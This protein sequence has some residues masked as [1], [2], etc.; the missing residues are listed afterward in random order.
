MTAWQRQIILCVVLL[1]DAYLGL[2]HNTGIIASSGLFKGEIKWLASSIEMMTGGIILVRIALGRASPRWRSAVIVFTPILVVLI[3]FVV[4]HTVLTGL[5]R[6]A[7]FNF[8]LSSIGA[9]GLYWAAVYLSIAI[10]LT[11]TYKVQRFANFAQA[12]MMLFGAY[13]A[14]T[15]MWSDR[16]FPI[17]NA[18]KDGILNWELMIWSAISAFVITGLVGLVIDRVVYRRF[19][20]RMVTP[21]IMMIASLGVSMVLRALLYLRF[22]AST[23]RFVPDRDWRLTTSIVEIPTQQLELNIGDR[24]NVPLMDLAANVN[25]YGFAYSKIALVAGIFGIVML[26][27]FLLHRTSLG[28]QMRA[29]ADNSDLAASS[30]IHVERV[31]GSTA[32]LSSGIA[33]FGGAFLAAILPVNPELGLSLLLPAFAVIVLGTIGSMPG[34]IIGALIVG[35][36]RAVSEP[37]LIGAG[38]AL[39]RP[40]ASGFA[41]VT[42]FIFLIGLL[43]LAPQG[44]GSAIQNWN[45]ERIRK[46]RLSQRSKG[47]FQVIKVALVLS[48]LSKI[49]STGSNFIY[50]CNEFKD[51]ATESIRNFIKR[52]S[53]FTATYLSLLSV[54]G[55]S[56]IAKRPT[57]LSKLSI[58]P[59]NWIRVNR[60]TERGSWTA[61]VILFLVLVVVVW[62]LPSVS[63][64]TKVLQVSRIIT[65]VAIFGLACFSLNLHTG[66]TGMTNFGVIF[67]VG[68]GAVTV[69]LLS[70]PVAT[71]GY[72]WNP[73]MAT[74]FAVGLSAIIGWLLAYPTARLRM[75]YF[76]IV[77]ISLG[78]MLRISL[79]A[80]PLLRA[81]TST[82]AM[83]ISQFS[84]PLQDWWKSGPSDTVGSLLGLHVPAPYVALLAVMATLSVIVVWFLLNTVLASPWGRI[85]RSI[86][87][88]EVVSQHH[89]HNILTHKAASLAL[90]AAVAALA[91]ALWAWLNTNVWP[92]F[93]NP[94]RT[95]FLIWAAFIVGGRGN[96]RGM[97]IGAFLIVIVEFVFNVMVISR[98]ATSLPFHSVT[99]YLDSAFSWLVV[100]IG[101][102]IWS[103]R[104]ITEIF[105]RGDVILSLPHLKLALVGIVIVGALLLSSKGL[106]PEVPGR[107]KRPSSLSKNLDN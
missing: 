61:F 46:R 14:L 36:L 25:P 42:P 93:M 6:A 4:L 78:E 39:D 41:E 76:A 17:S 8:N 51:M 50:G 29:V 86:R 2:I 49:V 92:D 106:L 104:S 23:H 11:L 35:L 79:Q 21:Q 15:L 7:T 64:L 47:L 40:T 65:L 37:V 56:P 30:G 44:I 73:W 24:I 9:S 63:N 38:N 87:D 67:F 3:G 53:G 45:I 57:L 102:I 26:V 18:P 101:G 48:T 43:L 10:G 74:I 33:G 54:I 32:F 71:N 100:N 58:H 20:N 60:Q 97:I 12:E 52:T 94:V 28:R 5:G 59:S 22:S 31:H 68:I 69:G 91:G 88:D 72:G 85:L 77:T 107:P 1:F 99:A 34:V 55:T 75:D 96:N 13:V 84:R 90:G 16:F 103:A 105:P 95:T 19:R 80:E 89:G 82:S 27:L 83:G 98:G 62:L 70:A 66:L 81:G